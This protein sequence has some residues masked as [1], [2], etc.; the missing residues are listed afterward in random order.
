LKERQKFGKKEDGKR[1]SKSVI[2]YLETYFLVED[3]N[4][5]EK[6]TTQE[7]HN[8]LKGLV[9]EGIL[10]KEEIPKVLTISNWITQY[11]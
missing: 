11:A 10:E 9:K 2:S 8:E 5:S 6:Y 1:I 4:K 7:M 3:I